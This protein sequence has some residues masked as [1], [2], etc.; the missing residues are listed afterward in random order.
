M[1]KKGDMVSIALI[2]ANVVFVCLLV[3]KGTFIASDAVIGN[4]SSD[5]VPVPL[6]TKPPTATP[7]V[8][9]Q[10][11]PTMTLAVNEGALLFAEIRSQP[12]PGSS[13]PTATPTPK[14][15]T[16]DDNI[17]QGHHRSYKSAANYTPAAKATASYRKAIKARPKHP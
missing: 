11:S 1:I 5:P 6:A 10:P 12:R 14:P 3:T 17:E 4:N 7:T 8:T 13:T 15:S 2:M 16:D 9:A